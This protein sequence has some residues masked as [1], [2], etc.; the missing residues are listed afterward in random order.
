M[1]T[2]ADSTFRVQYFDGVKWKFAKSLSQ[3]FWE[4]LQNKRKVIETRSHSIA[5]QTG[6][7]CAYHFEGK[8]EKFRII[9]ENSETVGQEEAYSHTVTL[10]SSTSELRRTL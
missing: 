4:R 10:D 1:A 7:M 5:L 6:M 2:T 9:N 3:T 8:P